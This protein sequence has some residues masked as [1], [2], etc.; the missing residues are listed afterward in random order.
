[1]GKWNCVVILEA[2][3]YIQNPKTSF[4]LAEMNTLI[5]LALAA[6]NLPCEMLTT[7]QWKKLAWGTAK[8]KKG[9]VLANAQK[10]WG[11]IV[12]DDHFGDALSMALAG[13][14]TGEGRG[15]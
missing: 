14:I 15:T 12:T 1:M 13:D 7:T 10:V 3:L 6:L 11:E 2:P 9:D 8:L 5:R 4:V